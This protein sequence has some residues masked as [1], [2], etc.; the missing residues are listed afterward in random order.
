MDLLEATR[1]FQGGC[2]IRD[3]LENIVTAQS[4]KLPSSTNN[5]A[6]AWALS[7]GFHLAQIV[8]ITSINSR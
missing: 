3:H 5:V 8:D 6:E 1:E 7:Y 2:V 4:I